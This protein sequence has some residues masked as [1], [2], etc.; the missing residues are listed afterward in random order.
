MESILNFVWERIYWFIGGGVAAI[1]LNIMKTPQILI[2]RKI[3]KAII[4]KEKQ[5][6]TE[7]EKINLQKYLNK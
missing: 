6:L 4:E 2:K 7:L 1:I 3:K 5:G